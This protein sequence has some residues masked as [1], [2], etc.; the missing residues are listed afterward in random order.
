[1]DVAASVVKAAREDPWPIRQRVGGFDLTGYCG[2][3][4][5]LGCDLG[6]LAA[7][8]RLSHGSTLSSARQKTGI[9]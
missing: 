6:S 9:R 8:K 3:A 1:M 2:Q 5:H 7:S 4:Q